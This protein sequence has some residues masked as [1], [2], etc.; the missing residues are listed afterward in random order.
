MKGFFW[1]LHVVSTANLWTWRRVPEIL[2]LGSSKGG[3]GRYIYF[4]FVALASFLLLAHSEAGRNINK[5]KLAEGR[6]QYLFYFNSK[7]PASA[8]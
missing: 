3:K 1:H 7:R 2:S 8:K 4:Y 5:I 6:Y